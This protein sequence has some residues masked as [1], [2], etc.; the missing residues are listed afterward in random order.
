MGWTF[1]SFRSIAMNAAVDSLKTQREETVH[2]DLKTRHAKG[3]VQWM[4]EHETPEERLHNITTDNNMDVFICG[5][6]GFAS[7]ATDIAKAKGSADIICWGFDPGMALV[8]HECM[9]QYPW[10]NGEPYGELLK[11]KAKQGIQ[12]RLLVWYD[13]KGSAKQNSLVGY[14]DPNYAIYP[15]GT[16]SQTWAEKN[17]QKLKNISVANQRQDYCTNWWREATSGQIKNLEVRCRNGMPDFVKASIADEKDKP[18][19][20]LPFSKVQGAAGLDEKGLLENHATHHQK[21]ILIDYDFDGGSQAVGYIMGLNSV[22]DYWDTA[23]HL[24]DDPNRE[25]YWGTAKDAE[26]GNDHAAAAAL[27]AGQSISKKP[28][29]DYA[30]RLQGEVLASVNKNFYTAWDKGTLL[31]VLL[32]PNKSNGNLPKSA[33]LKSS[34][35][36]LPPKLAKKGKPV[37]LQVLRTQPEEGYDDTEQCHAFDKTIKRGYFQASSTARNYLYLENQYFFYE[38]WSRHLKANRLAFLDMAQAGKAKKADMG[39]LH[40]M[41]VI[42]L[43]EEA[44]MIPRTFDTLKSLGQTQGKDAQGNNLIA[45]TTHLQ[46]KIQAKNTDD[47][48]QSAGKVKEP[49]IDKEGVLMQD[50]KSLGL[51]VLVCKMVTD[52]GLGKYRDIY[53]HSKLMMADDHYMTLGSANLNQRSM[54]ADSEINIATDNHEKVKEL[55]QR[56]WALQTGGFQ[57]AGGREGSTKHIEKAYADWKTLSLQNFEKINRKKKESLTG[58]IVTFSDERTADYRRG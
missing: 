2:I 14:V 28:Y 13:D 37:R 18:S 33:A 5:E 4:L 9:S 50:G 3:T 47:I 16:I 44:G 31:P 36:A 26:E 49:S 57:D 27:S 35:E 6:E 29:Q 10:A 51:K 11:R 1:K 15:S 8:R 46:E 25:E 41:V 20:A 19:A 39:V 12:V 34:R 30:A 32:G 52:G 48:V 24:Y 38:E 23:K 21:P 55:R 54:A 58:H 22:T 43:P 7:I 45:Q 17:P 56:V 42:P 40:A 53:I